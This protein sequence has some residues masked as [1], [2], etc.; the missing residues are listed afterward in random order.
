[1]NRKFNGEESIVQVTATI[2][3]AYLSYY[4]AEAVYHLSG[5][6]AVVFC[7]VVTKA[8]AESLIIDRAMMDKFWLLVEHLLNTVLFVL[9]GVI[10]GTVISNQDD[11]RQEDFSGRDWGYLILVYVLMT[12]IRFFLFACFFPIISNIGLKSHWKEMVFHAFGGLRGAVG[13][14][15]AIA[16]DNEVIQSTVFID[17]KRRGTSELF[18]LTGGI[19]LLTLFVNGMLAGPLLKYFKLGRASP[20]RLKVTNRYEAQMKK[21]LIDKL[22]TLL[23]EPRFAK[24]DYELIQKNVP[25]LSSLTISEVR[26]AVRR[27]K[28]Y[29]PSY[30]YMTPDLSL[31][32][33]W[34]ENEQEEFNQIKKLA[35]KT[36]GDTFRAAVN[37]VAL[38]RNSEMLETFHESSLDEV[39]HEELKELRLVFLELLRH[40]YQEDMAKGEVD[41]RYM[42]NTFKINES[43][44]VAE[45]NV[46]NGKPPGDWK[47]CQVPIL[48][49]IKPKKLVERLSMASAFIQAHEEA[50]LQFLSEFCDR[51]SLTDME[52]KVLEESRSQVVEA[53]KFIESLVEECDSSKNIGLG[54][55]AVLLSSILLNDYAMLT[56]EFLDK[57]LFKDAE[58]E[59]YFEHTEHDL[60]Q[61]RNCYSF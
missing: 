51:G 1:L 32:N 33:K 50:E 15:L 10:W 40:S 59:H 35:K 41:V 23:G 56:K 22:I 60:K 45:D 26:G 53:R 31:F 9:G 30:R 34:F 61:L 39:K 52:C 8:F 18:G 5:V 11:K 29:T 4:V 24:L 2:A 55:M 44:A 42:P 58:A 25:Q 19:S 20:A 17:P 3:V 12:L 7:G 38:H 48:S 16:L 46:S 54:V 13:I 37:S 36:V 47:E 28:E 43:L 49:F 6:I 57:G 21:R 14:A 27:V